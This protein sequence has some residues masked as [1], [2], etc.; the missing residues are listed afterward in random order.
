MVLFYP[1]PGAKPCFTPDVLANETRRDWHWITPCLEVN[2]AVSQNE[3]RRDEKIHGGE[4]YSHSLPNFS[5]GHLQAL[6]VRLP[7]ARANDT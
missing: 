7:R 5:I 1:P 4:S 3:P 2:H 6:T